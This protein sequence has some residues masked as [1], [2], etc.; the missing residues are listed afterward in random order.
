MDK[1]KCLCDDGKAPAEELFE[2]FLRENSEG[3]TA[4]AE[5]VIQ[6]LRENKDTVKLDARDLENILFFLVNS[7]YGTQ[8]DVFILVCAALRYEWVTEGSEDDVT[9]SYEEKTPCYD[10]LLCTV[11]DCS[12]VEEFIGSCNDDSC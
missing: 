8:T 5:S 7:D 11:G 10:H 9:E 3:D 4:K 2:K 1:E 6:H 12:I